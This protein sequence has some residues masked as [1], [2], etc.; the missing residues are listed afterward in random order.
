MTQTLASGEDL[1][2]GGVIDVER[3]NSATVLNE[4]LRKAAEGFG[5]S[6]GGLIVDVL[7][8]MFGPGKLTFDEYIALRLFD[9]SR[10]GAADR[11]AFVGFAAMRKIFATANFRTE[12]HGLVQ[13]KIAA[14]ALLS[15][16]GLTAAG[17]LALFCTDAGVASDGLL[18]SPDDLRDFLVDADFPLF[19][20]PLAGFQS[21]GAVSLDGYD[22]SSD[23]LIGADGRR[24]ALP[25]FVAEVA[26]HF[27]SGYLF[28]KRLTPHPEVRE[29]CGDRIAT[30]RVVTLLTKAGPKVFRACWKIPA[31]ANIADNY[32]RG[33]NLLAALDRDTGEISRVVSGKGVD[34]R[35]HTHHPDT[36]ASLLGR[37][38]PN[39]QEVVAAAL[40]GARVMKDVPL[41]GWDIAPVDGG[42]T[43]VE[44][45]ETPDFTLPQLAD[46]RGA[47][48]AEMLAFLDQRREDR[49][50]WLRFIR[51]DLDHTA[52]PSFWAA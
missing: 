11:R 44:M 16:F 29:I 21:L 38:V 36:G 6:Y 12:L 27:G 24:I 18:A 20:K 28:Q 17:T 40:E 15:A 51:S 25:V 45:N 2:Q 7:K 48:D 3:P 14:N 30:V 34:L 50:A 4:T 26:K 23:T 9:R 46:G 52:R 35:E 37:V 13:N 5:G 19:G 32:W 1:P 22:A 41:I 43:I 47:L 49:K 31:G 39:W 10:Y 33:G 8:T 42:A